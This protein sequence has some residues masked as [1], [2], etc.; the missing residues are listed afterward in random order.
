MGTDVGGLGAGRG[1]FAHQFAA[2]GGVGIV[3]LI[4]AEEAGDGRKG[5]ERPGGIDRDLLAG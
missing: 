1:E 2:E 4:V 5:A 3:R